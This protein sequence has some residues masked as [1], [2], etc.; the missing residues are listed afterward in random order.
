MSGRIG[1]PLGLRLGYGPGRTL[2][3]GI[4]LRLRHRYSRGVGTIRVMIL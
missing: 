4:K 2:R 1:V 3:L